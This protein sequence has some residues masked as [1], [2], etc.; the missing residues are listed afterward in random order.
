MTS[1]TKPA[2]QPK[3]PT[4]P[5]GDRSLGGVSK[6]APPPPPPAKK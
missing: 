6:L 3:P 1:N 5:N 2:P 4:S